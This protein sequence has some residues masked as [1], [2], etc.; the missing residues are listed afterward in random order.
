ME[1][2]ARFIVLRGFT[3]RFQ[4]VIGRGELI[5]QIESADKG[6]GHPIKGPFV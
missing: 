5:P 3:K 4:T 1:L 2:V 6:R